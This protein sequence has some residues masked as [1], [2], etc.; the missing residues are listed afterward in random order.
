M[1]GMLS[2]ARR[3][4]QSDVLSLEHIQTLTISLWMSCREVK[5]AIESPSAF[6]WITIFN[7]MKVEKKFELLLY[8]S[9]NNPE[10]SEE[11][12]KLTTIQMSQMQMEYQSKLRLLLMPDSLRDKPEG[13]GLR[14]LFGEEEI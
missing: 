5:R 6:N 4:Y 9:F 13:L 3:L 7:N 12:P 1:F 14:R 2:D 10:S 8:M 11:E